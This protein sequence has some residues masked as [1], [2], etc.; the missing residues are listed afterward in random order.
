MSAKQ[1]LIDINWFL[2]SQLGL[3]ARRFARSIRGLP[4]FLRD[5]RSFRATDDVRMSL[6]PCLQDRYEEA[7]FVRTEYFWQDLI[8]ARWIHEASPKRHVDVGSRI[9]GFVA[10]VAS[11]REIEVFDVRPSPVLI[12]GIVFR[13]ADLSDPASISSLAGNVDGYCDSLS[14]L[15]AL[16]H[17]GLGRYGDPVDPRAPL[18]GIANLARLV[19]PGGTLYLSTPVGRE[20]VRFNANWVFDPRS[21]VRAAAR[22]GLE[23]SSIATLGAD[24]ALTPVEPDGPVLAEIAGGSDRLGIF[25]FRKGDRP[26]C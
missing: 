14:C 25:T 22:S 2:S 23:V 11:F 4:A 20:R 26:A 12:P 5:F 7:G 10:H 24:G 8:V 6:K 17:F 15:H 16:E 21:I 19:R 13:R 1:V 9:D 3:D 18:K